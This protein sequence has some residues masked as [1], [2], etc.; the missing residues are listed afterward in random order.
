[1]LKSILTVAAAVN[2]LGVTPILA[3]DYSEDVA[4]CNSLMGQELGGG[5]V[6]Q[7]VA[8]LHGACC[9]IRFGPQFAAARDS[10][11]ALLTF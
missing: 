4:R 9:K 6:T 5:Y 2:C 7:A 11:Y 3:Q 10:F 1:M 8:H